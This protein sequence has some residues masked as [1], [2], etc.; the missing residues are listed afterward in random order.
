MGFRHKRNPKWNLPAETS[1]L[2]ND[3]DYEE[4]ANTATLTPLSI[5]KN[6]NQQSYIRKGLKKNNPENNLPREY[7]NNKKHSTPKN[8][9][10]KLKEN[11]VEDTTDCSEVLYTEVEEVKNI[12]TSRSTED[13]GENDLNF[14]HSSC[15]QSDSIEND[16]TSS[17]N[18]NAKEYYC[19]LGELFYNALS[20]TDPIRFNQ[21]INSE[22][23]L[24]HFF[25]KMVD[26]EKV[27]QEALKQ[28]E[29]H[30]KNNGILVRNL[31]YY[32]EQNSELKLAVE[33]SNNTIKSLLISLESAKEE[34]EK[35]REL[36]VCTENVKQDLQKALEDE[37]EL[38]VSTE[39]VKQ[40]LQNK[41]HEH[42]LVLEQRV[43]ISDYFVRKV[44]YRLKLTQHCLKPLMSNTVIEIFRASLKKLIKVMEEFNNIENTKFVDTYK[45]IDSFF[46]QL[47]FKRLTTIS[48]T[49]EIFTLV[50]EEKKLASENERLKNLV[51][52]QK[53]YLTHFFNKTYVPCNHDYYVQRLIRSSSDTNQ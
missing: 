16:E 17:D 23:F 12:E 32:K 46:D 35:E 53:K 42:N 39:N 27:L 15:D 40:E 4:E 38:R 6:N 20:E 21:E 19:Q 48:K 28:N 9:Q 29:I 31:A 45:G 13:L 43:E 25:S 52:E 37:K 14:G 30:V 7:L 41:L 10:I 8:E 26:E 11:Q 33:K 36:K 2:K 18:V 3:A 5:S 51:I 44:T 49:E 47:F 24:K 34:V 1:N 50:K 22:Q